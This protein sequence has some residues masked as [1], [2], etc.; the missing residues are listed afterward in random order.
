MLTVSRKLTRLC[1]SMAPLHSSSVQKVLN[2]PQRVRLRLKKRH[3]MVE[4]ET[5]TSPVLSEETAQGQRD[6]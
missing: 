2:Q 5:E 4:M 1:M 3:V 6:E